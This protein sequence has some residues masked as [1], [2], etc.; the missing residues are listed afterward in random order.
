M[1]PLFDD[2]NSQ[3][4]ITTVIALFILPLPKFVA[5]TLFLHKDNLKR[6][7]TYCNARKVSHSN[8]D[9]SNNEIPIRVSDL[10]IDNHVRENATICNM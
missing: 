8:S 1:L 7:A 10:V 4:V 9:I 3:E 5:M 6:I 2:F